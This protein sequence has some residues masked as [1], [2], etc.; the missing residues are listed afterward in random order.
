MSIWKRL[1]GK[2][3]ATQGNVNL[4][5]LKEDAQRIVL[6]RC[7]KCVA[8]ASEQG[9]SKEE[10]L[11]K[12][13]DATL[14]SVDVFVQRFGLSLDSAVA[15]YCTTSS[16]RSQSKE[17]ILNILKMTGHP[18]ANTP[19]LS[20]QTVQTST[21]QVTHVQGQ[22]SSCG[23]SGLGTFAGGMVMGSGQKMLDYISNRVWVCTGCRA[24]FC[25]DCS[26]AKYDFKCPNC[27]NKLES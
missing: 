25:P 10:M 20:S 24:A 8:L 1:F 14:G 12:Y 3:T 13:I 6:E 5:D 22:C 15:L 23:R 18:L 19:H 11:P 4:E 27:G 16:G 17:G 26:L 21:G 7:S 2:A 9:L